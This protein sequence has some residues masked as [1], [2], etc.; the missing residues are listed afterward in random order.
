MDDL[1]P[2][3]PVSLGNGGNEESIYRREVR[4]MLSMILLIFAL[5]LF[6]VAGSFVPEPW[7]DRLVC[8]GLACLTGAWIVE[9]AG[10]NNL[11]K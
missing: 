9:K 11:L 6:V 2:T 8:Y 7:K 10:G 3:R 4:K 5:V 1:L